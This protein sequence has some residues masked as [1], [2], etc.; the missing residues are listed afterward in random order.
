[1]ETASNDH[2]PKRTVKPVMK[3]SYNDLGKPSDK[4]LSV[5]YKGMVVHL[6]KSPE[7][8]NF[9]GTLWCHPV[10]QCAKCTKVNSNSATIATM[11]I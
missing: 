4:P 1:M 2:R 9:C 8:K 3:L 11:Q 10:A 5:V 7:M 6:G